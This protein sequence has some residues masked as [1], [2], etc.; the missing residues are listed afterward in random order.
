MIAGRPFRLRSK[1]TKLPM[2]IRRITFFLAAVCLAAAGWAQPAAA[3]KTE[4]KLVLTSSDARLVE[5]FNW[6]KKQAMAYVFDGDPVG[7]WYEAALPGR[8]AFCMRDTA[9]QAAGA[10]VLGLAR[11]NLN[12]LRRFAE[13]VSE[14]KDWCSYWEIDRYNRSAPVDY[15]NDAEF[16]YNL[17]ANFDILNAC[18]RMYVWTGDMTYINDPV[19]LNFYDRTVYEYVDRWDLSLDRI[20]SASAA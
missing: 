14:S 18:Y 2:W 12:M 15:K 6:A 19:F 13:N 1:E 3:G 20:M 10:H 16:W 11:Y 9:H 8:E 7:P 17:P 4:S 5:G